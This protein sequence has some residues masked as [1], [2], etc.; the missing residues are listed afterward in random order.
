MSSRENFSREK[1][2]NV[3]KYYSVYTSLKSTGSDV[4]KCLEAEA[5]TLRGFSDLELKSSYFNFRVFDIRFRIRIELYANFYDKKYGYIKILRIK[6]NKKGIDRYKSYKIIRLIDGGI[7]TFKFNGEIEVPHKAIVSLGP[8]D[9]S[10][11]CLNFLIEQIMKDNF[12]IE[13]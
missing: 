1:I 9:F 8:D 13:D 4:L 11:Y 7:D 3:Q 10:G 6:R 12:L 5:K 2:N